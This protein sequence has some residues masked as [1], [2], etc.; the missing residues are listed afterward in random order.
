MTTAYF[1]A[2]CFGKLPAFGDFVRHNAGGRDVL[3]FDTW[4]QQGLY[5]ARVQLRAEWDASFRGAPPYHFLFFPENS[6]SFLIGLLRPSHDR[7]AR[8]FPFIV[9]LRVDRR[10]P[11]ELVPLA[12]AV[13][14]PFFERA[15]ALARYAAGTIALRELGEATER[16]HA[17]VAQDY[18]AVLRAY[19]LHLECTPAG[20]LWSRLW[21]AGRADDE[22][23]FVVFHNLLDTLL[24]L[25][26][27]NPERLALGLRFPVALDAGGAPLAHAASF[28]LDAAF[29]L[30]GGRG[31]RPFVFWTAPAMPNEPSRPGNGAAPPA[32][33]FLFLR[34]PTAR[35]V[36]HLLRPDLDSEIIYEMDR[37]GPDR[38]SPARAALPPWLGAM[39]AEPTTPLCRVIDALGAQRP[40]LGRV[41][42]P[43]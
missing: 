35:S 31:V 23:P 4:L 14:A 21:G 38:R 26:G 34:Q 6:E 41:S 42:V 37:I 11:P 5:H 43:C 9:T 20:A 30:V 2:S 10:L 13:F 36:L 24:P 17:P 15:H 27:R 7:S 28:W 29:R 32:H 39:L 40:D 22:R 18:A 19:R 3:A 25:R 8:R 16:L 1:P 33:L 12:P